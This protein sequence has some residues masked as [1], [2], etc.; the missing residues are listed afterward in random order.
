VDTV[1]EK[2]FKFKRRNNDSSCEERQRE[3]ERERDRERDRETETER[4]TERETETDRETERE[5]ETERGGQEVKGERKKERKRV[6]EARRATFC[7]L[8]CSFSVQGEAVSIKTI[9]LNRTWMQGIL[10]CPLT[11]ANAR[12]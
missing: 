8:I 2:I 12:R 4:E 7:I 6:A 5:T 9:S 3:R 10:A 11:A 1:V